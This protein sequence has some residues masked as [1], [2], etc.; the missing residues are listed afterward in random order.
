MPG[1]NSKSIRDVVP[2]ALAAVRK[3][4]QMDG[5]PYEGVPVEILAASSDTRDLSK[6]SIVLTDECL[7]TLSSQSLTSGQSLT[8]LNLSGAEKITDLGI[9]ALSP[10]LPQLHSLYL[11]NLFN[12]SSVGLAV[13]AKY[14]KK[15]KR[16]SLA[17]CLKIDGVGFATIGD[18]SRE[19]QYLNLSGCQKI[20]P[21]AFMNIFQ[22]AS[23][24]VSLD[25]SYCSLI[26]D[27]EIKI[28]SE[29]SKGLRSINLRE[30]KLV[31]DVGVTFL[32]Q[33]CRDLREINLRRREMPFRIT[34]VALLQLGQ[35]CQSLVSIN[36]HGCEMISDSGLSWLSNWLKDL[37]QIDL[38]RC[39]KITNSGLR[40]L[41][42]GCKNLQSIVLLN[43]KR[44][45]D[46]GLRFVS[47]GCCNLVHLNV[48]G[49]TLLS[50]GVDRTFAL[51]GLQ[52][53][54]GSKCSSTLKYLNL[55]GCPQ[56]CNLALIAI[57]NLSSLESLDLSGCTRLTLA[58]AS[59]IGKKC[60]LLKSISL[61]SCGD[62]V[63]NALFEAIILHARSLAVV[64]LSFCKKISERSLKAMSNYQNL[65]TLDLTGCASVSDTAILFLC[66]GT[67]NPGL[68]HLLMAGCSKIT[69]TSLSW[70]ADGLKTKDGSLSLETLSL[71]GTR[72]TQ[73]AMKGIQDSF[74]Y[75]SL[76]SNNSYFGA[77]PLSRVADRRTIN[78]YHK[79][80]CAAAKIQALVRS[81]QEKD[82]L[83]RARVAYAKKLVALRIGAL[84]RGGKARRTF[85]MMKMERKR[86]IV[87]CRKLQCAFR[88]HAAKRVRRR[89]QR[90]RMNKL[91]PQ[92]CKVI[93]KHYRGVLGRRKAARARYEAMLEAKRRSQA[94]LRIQSWTR[95]I[96]ACR[97][98]AALKTEF[99]RKEAER[100]RCAIHIQCAW[101][102]HAA[103]KQLTELKVAF[104]EQRRLELAAAARIY[105]IF[106]HF[107]FRKAIKSRIDKS[108]ERVVSTLLI[109]RWYRQMKENIRRRIMNEKLELESR[110]QAAIVIQRNA[111]KRMSYL[112]FLAARKE[113]DAM[114]ALRDENAH[115]LCHFGRLCIAK[116]RMQKRREAFDEEVRRVYLLGMWAATVISSA[117]RGKVG[118]DTAK[119][120]RAIRAQRWK[121][122]WS[123]DEMMTF[124]YNLDTGETRW[125]KPQVLLDLEPK[126]VCCNCS[127]YLA[128]IECQECEEFYCT[129]CFQN[130]HMGGK[131]R[132]HNYKTVYDYY[133]RRRDLN[134]E[135]WVPLEDVKGD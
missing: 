60:L 64:N 38:S 109:Q 20:K 28:L 7:K 90:K 10:C 17:G 133:G 27:D 117:W 36:L 19:L 129:P 71:K 86:Q 116:S 101:R 53:L 11:E 88:C 82:T 37:Q 124:Y 120:A 3:V 8:S 75:S 106:R 4:I 111:R 31:S 44:V 59:Y 55:H 39:N 126:P 41:S 52:S 43:V 113:R 104:M 49:L 135:P 76:R 131:R 92:A 35:G 66:E 134:T 108:K 15:L 16:L 68:K 22:S 45:G 23:K 9:Q 93:Q 128:E 63:T 32:S 69:D 103:K 48:S 114:L 83:Q 121:A 91:M 50:D 102:G 25:V 130:I 99:L 65:Q 40:L 95:M 85:M 94:A 51:E 14:A 5:L 12:I 123:E 21:W 6:W 42:E 125:S 132:T 54:G 89:L 80:A 30:C 24:I 78:L 115:I 18:C 34:D 81:R 1:R 57:S 77:W 62:C 29:S 13:V 110:M 74:A 119:A 107:G 96:I 33:G 26:T 105:A 70:I 61:A 47:T 112:L 73:S 72:V 2:S 84:L 79:R 46:V 97:L 122:L 67:Y 58:G 127:S 87:S 98:K 100:L 118:R 56:I